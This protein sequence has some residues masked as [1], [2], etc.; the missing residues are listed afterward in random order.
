[1]EASI[2]IGKTKGF[3]L[4]EILV[5]MVILALLAATVIPLVQ[6]SVVRAKEAALKKNLQTI[7]VVIDDYYADHGKYPEQLES[8]V[9]LKYVRSLPKDPI[10]EKMDWNLTYEKE[11]DGNFKGIVDIHSSSN[12]TSLDGESYS[13]W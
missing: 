2:K 9:E 10:T 3:S 4:L 5:A 6:N 11:N 1:M 13:D 8:L 7:R 12:E